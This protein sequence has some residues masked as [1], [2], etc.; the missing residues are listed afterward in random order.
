MYFGFELLQEP[1]NRP[2]SAQSDFYLFPI[3]KTQLPG[4]QFGKT[5]CVVEDCL[6]DQGASF[7]LEGIALHEHRWTKCIDVI[8]DYCGKK[9]VW[10]VPPLLG[11]AANFL[12]F[13][14]IGQ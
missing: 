5:M 3:F 14:R 9:K 2:H 11:E 8:G 13:P 10:I 12:N 6:G 7:F 1:P 4:C